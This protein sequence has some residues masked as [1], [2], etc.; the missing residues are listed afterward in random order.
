MLDQWL[1]NEGKRPLFLALTP[2]EQLLVGNALQR[3]LAQRM[4]PENPSLGHREVVSLLDANV[5]ISERLGVSIEEFIPD[6]IT[7][8]RPV[9]LASLEQ[10]DE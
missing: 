4:N 2:S 3:S 10:R 9:A 5:K 8:S 6:C 7:A 1:I